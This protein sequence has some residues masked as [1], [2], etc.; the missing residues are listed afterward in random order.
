MSLFVVLDL[1]GL[2]WSSPHS[3]P[4]SLTMKASLY[5]DLSTCKPNKFYFNSQ[6]LLKFTPSPRCKTLTAS[7]ASLRLGLP[8]FIAALRAVTRA[9]DSQSEARRP[10]RAWGSV[11]RLVTV[12]QWNP[13]LRLGP[14]RRRRLLIAI[15][16]TRHKTLE[17]RGNIGHGVGTGMS[18]TEDVTLWIWIK[19]EF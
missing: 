6:L 12:K 4:N 15:W 2:H 16:A 18:G 1:F 11:W 14:L 19:C 7:T 10:N 3:K 13:A 5:D 9:R 17:G 8:P